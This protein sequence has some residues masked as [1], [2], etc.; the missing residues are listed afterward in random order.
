MPVLA[1]GQPAGAQSPAQIRGKSCQEVLQSTA[2][3]SALKG[4]SLHLGSLLLP[5]AKCSHKQLH[6]TADPQDLSRAPDKPP[7]T[8]SPVA[9]CV[10][11]R[12]DTCPLHMTGQQ[13]RTSSRIAL[14]E[15]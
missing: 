15:G 4:T 14:P 2:R 10:Q 11:L 7:F 3:A 13:L 1:T 12:R 9:P 5:A 8:H 6:S